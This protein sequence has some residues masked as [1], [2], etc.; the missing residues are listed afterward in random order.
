MHLRIATMYSQL[1]LTHQ[2][3]GIDPSTTHILAPKMVSWQHGDDDTM[4]L[5]VDGS[6]LTNPGKVGHGGLIRKHDDSFQLGFF[7]SVGISN[8]LHVE[9]QPL[10]IRIKLCWEAGYKKKTYVL[11]WLSSCGAIGV[12]KHSTFSSLCKYFGTILLRIGQLLFTI[13]FKKEI[14]VETFSLSWKLIVHTILSRSMSLP[15]VYHLL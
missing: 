8:I 4:I 14:H 11:F 1:Q 2:A 3:F 9:I 15:F 12:E 13:S 7:E 6:A 5:N 10:W